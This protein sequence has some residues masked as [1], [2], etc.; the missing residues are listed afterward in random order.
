MDAALA[1]P[2]PTEANKTLWDARLERGPFTGS[3]SFDRHSVSELVADLTEEELV[4]ETEEIPVAPLGSG[5]DY[6]VML[7]RLGVSIL[8]A[9]WEFTS[10][11]LSLRSQAP[12][13]ALDRHYL[14]QCIIITP[15]MTPRL[16]RRNTQIPGST[17]M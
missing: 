15:F 11:L 17:N 6:T 5:S 3:D 8:S 2:H 12:I 14:T 9:S 16:G 7:Q 10:Q 4:A 1:V 13:W